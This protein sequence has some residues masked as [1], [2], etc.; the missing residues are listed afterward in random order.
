MLQ[1]EILFWLVLAATAAGAAVW[2][3]RGWWIKRKNLHLRQAFYLGISELLQDET[4]RALAI[5]MRLAQQHGEM[6]ELQL[7]LANLFRQRGEVDRA[8]RIHQSLLKQPGLTT[9]LKREVMAGLG[10]DFMQ[11]GV[12]D[13]AERHF[14][15]LETVGELPPLALKS[16]V[17]IYEMERDWHKAIRYSLQLERQTGKRLSDVVAHYYCELAELSLKQG[18]VPEAQER[19]TQALA[20]YPGSARA[21]M[22][23]AKLHQEQGEMSRALTA[24]KLALEAR[25]DLLGEIWP[26]LAECHQAVHGGESL[27][28]VLDA[29]VDK[30]PSALAQ[31][32]RARLLEQEKGVEAAAQTLKTGLQKHPSITGMEQWLRLLRKQNGD[33]ENIRVLADIVT[34]LRAGKRPWHCEQCGFSASNFHWHC[35]GCNG[36]GSIRYAHRGAGE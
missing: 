28:P 5:F 19:I 32:V 20:K 4:D 33:D 14:L 15:S 10:Q 26:S 22:M 24:W 27:L 12:Y 23:E 35:P 8:I 21:R 6:V 13:R 2:Y 31:V 3:L 29:L 17:R 30:S 9:D 11:A 16:L 18:H 7:M 34:G 36:W 25:P 1:V